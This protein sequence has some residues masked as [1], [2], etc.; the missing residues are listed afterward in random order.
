M[1]IIQVMGYAVAFMNLTRAID[2]ELLNTQF[3]LGVFH[4]LRKPTE[5]DKSA[6][7]LPEGQENVIH[8]PETLS[9][10]LDT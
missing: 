1:Y 5:E 3:D 10:A 9:S 6:E 8:L 4:G 7:I 2:L